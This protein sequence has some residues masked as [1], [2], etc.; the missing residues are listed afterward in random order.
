MVYLNLFDRTQVTFNYG[1]VCVVMH[2]AAAAA[3]RRDLRD[4]C[5]RTRP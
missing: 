2:V 3:A 1:K 4:P 5:Q